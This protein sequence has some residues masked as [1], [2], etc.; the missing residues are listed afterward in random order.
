MKKIDTLV[1]DI[2]DLFRNN[3]IFNKEDVVEFGRALGEKL[4]N[5]ISEEKGPPTLRLSNL[6]TPCSRKLWYSINCHQLAEPLSPATRLKFL[7][8]DILEE[9]LLFLARAAGHSVVDE[10]KT[11][12]V[13]GVVGHIDAIVDGELVDCKSASTYSFN[14]FKD[15]TL[16]QD[17]AFGYLTQL[18]SYRSAVGGSRAHFLAIDK[19]LGHVTLDT[20]EDDGTDYSKLA[21]DARTVLALPHPPERAYADVPEG[22]SG[23]RK[24][25]VAC[26]YCAFKDTCWPGLR[27]YHYARGPVYLTHVAREPR[28][29]EG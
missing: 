28:V 9:L 27:E 2:Y 1:D 4:A 20:W 5:R 21:D 22:K 24:L 13:N 17:D 11:V 25:G 3:V 10:Q 18:G 23:N 7:F 8:G 12:E 14:K 16:G 26:S 19:T 29:S 15:H 6:G